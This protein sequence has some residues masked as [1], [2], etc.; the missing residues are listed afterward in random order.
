MLQNEGEC[1]IQREA[2]RRN[3]ESKSD[4]WAVPTGVK[5]GN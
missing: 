2:A 3:E 4:F 1:K 5:S